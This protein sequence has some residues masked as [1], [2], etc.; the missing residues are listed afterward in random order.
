MTSMTSPG[1]SP[2]HAHREK[3]LRGRAP[4]VGSQS[5]C[6]AQPSPSLSPKDP[7]QTSRK[8]AG[9]PSGTP[10]DLSSKPLEKP[11]R[12]PSKK[13][14]LENAPRSLR[15]PCKKP[16]QETPRDDFGEGRQRAFKKTF[17]KSLPETL[18]EEF[19]SLGETCQ[20]PPDKIW[21]RERCGPGWDL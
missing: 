20:K 10:R 1:Q 9:K 3:L 13:P 12:N 15:T 14:F 11:S 2:K 21:A 16:F 19:Q 6:L 4:H 17:R 18:R 8:C 5:I 7:K